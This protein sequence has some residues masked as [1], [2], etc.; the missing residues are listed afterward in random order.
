MKENT[1]VRNPL[2]VISIFAG[3][4]E[5]AG[6]AILPFVSEANQSTYI[7]FLIIFP[8]LLVIL[9]FLTLN[10]N[11]KVLYAPSDFRDE[12]NYMDLF[13]PSSAAERQEKLEEEIKATTEQEKQYESSETKESI[14]ELKS[15]M[16]HDLNFL[17][18]SLVRNPRSRFMLAE[19]LVIEKLSQELQLPVRREIALKNSRFIFDAVFEGKHGPILV[20]VKYLKNR[21]VH[22]PLIRKTL[23]ILKDAILSMPEDMRRNAKLILAIVHE[24]P[25]DELRQVADKINELI[26]DFPIPVEIKLYQFLLA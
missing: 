17:I 9:F 15:Y 14:N 18:D 23:T 7:W 4:A 2:T 3:L 10:F 24:L 20:D 13:R 5:V 12:N 25:P 19:A 1:F 11:P 26:S 16:T 8:I 22:Y 21:F 6:T